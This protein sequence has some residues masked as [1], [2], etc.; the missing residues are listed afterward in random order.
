[1]NSPVCVRR[2]ED[3]C[4]CVCVC[5]VKEKHPGLNQRAC[6]GVSDLLRALKDSLETI[7]HSLFLFLLLALIHTQPPGE[8]SRR[9]A[10]TKKLK[11]AEIRD[12]GRVWQKSTPCQPCFFFSLS[13]SYCPLQ[14]ARELHQF[15]FDLLIKSHMVSVD[16]PEMMAEIIS[17]QV[18]KILSGKVKPIYFHTQ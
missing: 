17:V 14:I 7:S 2:S 15:T 4:V 3:V 11:E 10:G 18:P 1:M 12:G 9:W 16:F 5:T 13:L 6:N 8:R